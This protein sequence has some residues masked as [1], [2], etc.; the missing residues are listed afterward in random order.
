MSAHTPIDAAVEAKRSAPRS[1]VF[2]AVKLQGLSG[3]I[4]ARLLDLSRHGALLASS[5]DAPP[6]GSEV[7]IVRGALSVPGRVA[8][9][10]GGRF[11][12]EFHSSLDKEGLLSQSGPPSAAKPQTFALSSAPQTT[13]AEE[14][15]LART[16]NVA[17]ALTVPEN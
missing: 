9:A 7:A 14:R 10:A 3:Q 11:G 13:P 1:H 16:W 8:W 17:V 12:I 4:D 6:V 2:L 15:K 5:S